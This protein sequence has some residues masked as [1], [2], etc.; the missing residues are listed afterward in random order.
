MI[1]FR[2]LMFALFFLVFLCGN[3]YSQ[4]LRVIQNGN[5]YYLSN[6]VIVKLKTAAV[7]NLNKSISLSSSLSSKLILYKVQKV[8]KTFLINSSSSNSLNNIVTIEYSS[9]VDPMIVAAKVR[10]LEGVLWAEPHYVYKIN[11]VPNDPSYSLQWSLS[12][13]KAQE[14]WDISKGDTS[15]IIAIV[16]T[17]IDWDHPDLAANIWINRNENPNNGVDDDHNGFVDDYRGWDFGGLSGSPDNNPMEDRPDHGTHVA[18]I[19]S[20][21][22]DNSVGVASI[23]SKCKL[24]AVKTSQDNYRDGNGNPYIAYGY[25]GIVYAADNGAKVINC[26]WGGSG[27]SMLSQAVINYTL[28][29]GALVVAGSGNNGVSETEFPAGYDGVLSVASTGTSDIKSSFSNYGYTVDVCAPGES[30]YS[31]WMND[32]Y[33]YLQGTS[34]SSPCAAGLAGLVF[35]QFPN[36][37]PMQVGEQIRV[38]C[39]N[40]DNINSS[41]AKQLGGGRI[42][43]FKALSN[44]NSISVRAYSIQYTDLTTGGDG[45]GIFKPGEEVQIN[46]KFRNILN[47][48]SNLV[49]NLQ[50]LSNFATVENPDYNAGTISSQDSLTVAFKFIINQNVPYDYVQSF[51]INYNDGSYS[52]FQGL[53]VT[54]NPTYLTQGGNEIEMTVTSKGNLGFN[55]YADNQQGNGFKYKNG[56]NLLFEGALMYGTTATNVNNVARSSD[57][58]VQSKDFSIVQPFTLYIPGAIADQEGL[59]IFNDNSSL[60]KLGITTKLHTYSFAS[61]PLEKSIIL[62]YRFTNKGRTSISNLY[63]GLYFD[64]DLYGGSTDETNYDSVNNFGYVHPTGGQPETYVGCALIS[65]ANYGYYAIRNEGGDGGFGV[66]DGFTDSEKWEAL[67]SGVFKKQA[68]PSDISMVVSSG[69]YSLTVGDS[70]D[71]AFAISAGDN[72]ADV[73]NSINASRTKFSQIITDV[74]NKVVKESLEFRLEQNYPNPFN[75]VTIINYEL[76][77]TGKVTLKVYD[78]LGNEVATLVNEEK[79]AGKY[80]VEFNAANLPNGKSAFSSGVYFY[81]L[82]SAGFTTTKKFILLK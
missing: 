28:S 27:F 79:S 71:V 65:S 6:K 59:T 26:S 73:Q 47:A 45:N 9:E 11:F 63:T 3:F 80:Q 31:T 76:G 34:M 56:S 55:D 35:S 61:T 42:N 13:I 5:R 38:N 43:A 15:V 36:L 33:A 46:V 57:A 29:K 16:D 64:W 20:A 54:V 7:D 39:D 17:G 19:A 50:S 66:Y 82:Q 77:I 81:K 18:G 21:V 23:G 22:T 12:K 4:N 14:A 69:P 53:N 48:T 68:G 25:E 8:S 72:L 75:P 60:K 70:V 44:T 67:S 37:S 41:F 32:G 40:I 24:M 62:H 52:D 74:E 51:L 49:I 30:I 1:S 2:K 58:G 10:S 78:V